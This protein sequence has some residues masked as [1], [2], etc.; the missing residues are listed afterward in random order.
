MKTLAHEY[1]YYLTHKA[2]FDSQYP[3]QA[4]VLKGN[5]IIG[6]Y[7]SRIEAVKETQKNHEAGTFLVQVCGP[8]GDTPL[9]FHSRV[10][11]S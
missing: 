5:S 2:D 4:I 3:G 7:S 1:E 11:F 9:I 6:V 8:E 10:S